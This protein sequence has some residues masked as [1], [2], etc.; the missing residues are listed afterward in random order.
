MQLDPFLDPAFIDVDREIQAIQRGDKEISLFSLFPFFK[1]KMRQDL[2]Q[3]PQ[4]IDT[5]NG[6]L[7][8]VHKNNSNLY[9]DRTMFT[10]SVMDTSFKTLRRV[11]D[12]LRRSMSSGSNY[13]TEHCIL[14]RGT[15]SIT[16]A[17]ICF[18]VKRCRQLFKLPDFLFCPLSNK[19]SSQISR[20]MIQSQLNFMLHGIYLPI[21]VIFTG[22]RHATSLL[23]FPILD[24]EQSKEND[25]DDDGDDPEE[26]TPFLRTTWN[27][28]HINPNGLNIEWQ[29]RFDEIPRRAY[30][31][32]ETFFANF[33]V[34]ST[35]RES[36]CVQNIQKN[37]ASCA[38]W[39]VIL[40]FYIFA[41]IDMKDANLHFIPVFCKNLSQR[42]LNSKT[43]HRFHKCIVDFMSLF[44][45]LT[46]D[47][48]T[49]ATERHHHH[50][51]QQ[52][53][54]TDKED[55]QAPTFSQFM[56]ELE[57]GSISAQVFELEAEIFRTMR[58]LQSRFEKYMTI[59]DSFGFPVTDY[60]EESDDETDHEKRYKQDFEGQ[61]KKFESH[62]LRCVENQKQLIEL[63]KKIQSLCLDSDEKHKCEL[64]RLK[65]Q[66]R[67]KAREHLLSLTLFAERGQTAEDWLQGWFEEQLQ[68]KI[69]ETQDS[70][71][72]L[73]LLILEKSGV[74]DQLDNESKLAS[75]IQHLALLKT[76]LN[77]SYM[78]ITDA[79]N[80][81]KF[82]NGAEMSIQNL[83]T[84]QQSLMDL[85]REIEVLN[86]SEEQINIRELSDLHMRF[87]KKYSQLLLHVA[88]TL[89][90]GQDPREWLEDWFRCEM[91]REI[92]T[93]TES[94]QS[95]SSSDKLW[96]VYTSD[97]NKKLATQFLEFANNNQIYLNIN[98][99]CDSLQKSLIQL[100]KAI[101]S[102]LPEA[103]DVKQEFQEKSNELFRLLQQIF[104]TTQ[105]R[106]QWIESWFREYN[107]N[108]IAQ[109]FSQME[110]IDNEIDDQRDKIESDDDTTTAKNIHMLEKQLGDLDAKRLVLLDN[111]KNNTYIDDASEFL[112]FTEKI[113]KRS[114]AE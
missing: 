81:L 18:V 37:Y 59:V 8:L 13:V 92:M 75:L 66:F 46:F 102:N 53:F 27:F 22:E 7:V 51:Q 94:S 69:R 99:K 103:D 73:E 55:L 34:S 39:S 29:E 78:Y 70:K 77:T 79:S 56:H 10:Q 88:N 38:P 58:S 44:L 49:K 20:Q 91:F 9:L 28:I 6:S 61:R 96:Q 108:E 85:K 26:K 74:S 40:A 109:Y 41:N 54:S 62:H 64:S 2:L 16:I 4:T 84:I 3:S 15:L 17:T 63:K 48:M 11:C 72:K 32:Y 25:D 21:L 95:P 50:Q 5:I 80:F 12:V 47:I 114:F 1:K 82:V 42:T 98:S 52:H 83:K 71:K 111:F 33:R 30:N 68:G 14:Q 93:L 101:Q 107:L 112:T 65:R 76:Q 87:H 90:C 35:F 43:L 86:A 60:I 45:F 89:H 104:Q 24:K 113:R 67:E 97:K 36:H 19:S 106:K 110:E 100:K 31:E 23:I 105:G 57:H